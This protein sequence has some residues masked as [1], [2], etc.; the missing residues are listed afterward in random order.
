MRST[1]ALR[2]GLWAGSVAS[3]PAWM[4]NFLLATRGQF[5][6]A[7]D[8]LKPVHGG[9]AISVHITVTTCNTN[10]P[11]SQPNSSL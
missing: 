5:L 8:N 9:T 1:A 7:T 6:V 3:W 10:D 4:T 11:A 2:G